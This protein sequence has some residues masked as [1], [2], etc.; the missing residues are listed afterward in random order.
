MNIDILHRPTALE[1][2]LA[3]RIWPAG[4]RL[5]MHVLNHCEQRFIAEWFSLKLHQQV[6]LKQLLKNHEK[7]NCGFKSV[8]K[9]K[10]VF[11]I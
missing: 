6:S 2:L 10:S 5:P 7:S 8:S 11:G 1:T 3:G 4:R 9:E